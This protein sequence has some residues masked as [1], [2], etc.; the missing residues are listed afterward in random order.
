[1]YYRK[2]DKIGL[3]SFHFSGPGIRVLGQ[4]VKV[5]AI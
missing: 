5:A 3:A 1:M 4:G 2:L